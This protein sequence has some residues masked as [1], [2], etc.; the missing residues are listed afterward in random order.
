MPDTAQ[1]Q[2]VAMARDPA[3][4][5]VVSAALDR[6]VDRLR[7]RDLPGV[8]ELFEPNAIVSG[9]GATE[10]AGGERVP[11]FFAA[12][13]AQP[14]TIGWTWDVPLAERDGD[15]LWFLAPAQFRSHGDNGAQLGM[16]YRLS[17]VL[18]RQGV[19]SGSS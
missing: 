6:F 16:A 10:Q 18:R 14:F 4:A 3:P 19:V 7:H 8:L 17:G 2:S 1:G 12:V 13:F 5:D 9:A 15:L 11:T